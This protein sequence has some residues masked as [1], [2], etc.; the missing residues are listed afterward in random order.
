MWSLIPLQPLAGREPNMPN[1]GHTHSPHTSANWGPAC[2]HLFRHGLAVRVWKMSGC[3]LRWINDAVYL[4]RLLLGYVD[5]VHKFSSPPLACWLLLLVRA[6][7]WG[8]EQRW[9]TKL[10][11][12]WITSEWTEKACRQARA[13][14][15]DRESS[16]SIDSAPRSMDGERRPVTTTINVAL[17]KSWTL[18]SCVH[19][20][21]GI[22]LSAVCLFVSPHLANSTAS[23][24]SCPYCSS[25]LSECQLPHSP[26]IILN[27][28]PR[29]LQITRT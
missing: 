22:A 14:R 13:V 8:R 9:C 3:H 29:V 1:S 25:R 6:S 28:V 15:A 19:G 4:L 7:E 26:W 10:T 23:I 21:L 2:I 17:V 27:P 18:N 20:L 16:S 24:L 5:V 11:C 12:G